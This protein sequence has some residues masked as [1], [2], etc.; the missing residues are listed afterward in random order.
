MHTW[1][2][3]PCLLLSKPFIVGPVITTLRYTPYSPYVQLLF[4]LSLWPSASSSAICALLSLSSRETFDPY[5]MSAADRASQCSA[6]RLKLG[7][8]KVSEPNTILFAQC[9]NS[10]YAQQ[11]RELSPNCVV[12]PAHSSDVALVVKTVSLLNLSGSQ[13]KLAIRGG[14]H[15]PNPGSAN[16][17]NG[18]TMHMR[19]MNAVTVSSDRSIVSMGAGA[20]WSEAYPMLD[21]MGLSISGGR[22]SNVGVAGLTLGGTATLYRGLL[23]YDIEL[24]A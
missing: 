9:Q 24:W 5:T 23:Y 15:S 22:L 13:A 10:Y 17:N 3:V 20:L 4:Y 6:L 7:E 1:S 19:S 11:E 16:I 21:A 18:I 8:D 2:H 12:R 14:G